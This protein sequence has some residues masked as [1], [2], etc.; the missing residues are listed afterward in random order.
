MRIVKNVFMAICI[1]CI[2]PCVLMIALGAIDVHLGA[3]VIKL[4]WLWPILG[5]MYLSRRPWFTKLCYSHFLKKKER[6]KMRKRG[7][8]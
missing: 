1:T 2:L 7:N 3:I 4:F 5:W 8:E 6:Q